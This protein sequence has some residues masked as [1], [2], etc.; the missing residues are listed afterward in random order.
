MYNAFYLVLLLTI[1]FIINF[2]Q[3]KRQTETYIHFKLWIFQCLQDARSGSI[4]TVDVQYVCHGIVQLPCIVKDISHTFMDIWLPPSRDCFTS[5]S[6]ETELHDGSPTFVNIYI[7]ILDVMSDQAANTILRYVMSNMVV[8][9]G[10]LLFEWNDDVDSCYF[11]IWTKK[12]QT[13]V[14]ERREVEQHEEK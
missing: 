3:G 13:V 4:F 10:E 9:Y 11:N 8:L 6:S 12:H 1:L 2:A 14:R 5:S 7:Y